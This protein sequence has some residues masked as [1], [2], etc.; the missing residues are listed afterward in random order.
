MVRSFTTHPLE[1]SNVSVTFK[2]SM[3]M[4]R[5]TTHV[6]MSETLPFDVKD[7]R[8][9]RYTLTLT[10]SIYVSKILQNINHIIHPVHRL[11][12]ILQS[13]LCFIIGNILFGVHWWRTTNVVSTHHTLKLDPDKVGICAICRMWLNVI[14]V[15]VYHVYQWRDRIAQKR[16]RKTE[17][18]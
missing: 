8:Y 12:G 13:I 9:T 3:K 11:S 7:D 10:L 5:H 2:L 17:I 16:E 18:N 6:G 14:V 1:M 4:H 15:V